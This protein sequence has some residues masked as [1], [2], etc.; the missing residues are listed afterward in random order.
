MVCPN[1][2]K[3]TLQSVASAFRENRYVIKVPESVRLPA[4]QALD[5][6]LAV[7]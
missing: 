3:T 2:K 4:K 1:M 6:M 5:R 7:S